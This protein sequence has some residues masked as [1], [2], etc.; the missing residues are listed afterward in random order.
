MG[1]QYGCLKAILSCTTDSD[2]GHEV[3]YNGQCKAVCRNNDDCSQNEKCIQSL[4][5]IPCVG[6]SQCGD[7]QACINGTCLLGCRTDNNCPSKQACINGKC[8]NPCENDGVCGP[9]AICSCE[10]HSVICKCPDG[11]EG[12]PTPEQACIRVPASCAATKDCPARHMCIANKCGLPCV[13][14]AHCAIG[15]RCSNNI[16]VKVCHA[17]SNCLPGDVC[18]KGVCQAGCSTDS[19]CRQ[20]EICIRNQCKCNNGFIAT[21]SGCVDINECESHPCHSSAACENEIGSYR[22]SCPKGTAGDPFVE[23]GCIAPSQCMVDVQCSDNLACRKGK[24]VDTCLETRCGPN[25]VC[26]MFNHLAACSCPPGHLGN[27]DD[28]ELGCFK[29]ECTIDSDCT[30]DRYCDVQTNKC[31]SK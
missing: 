2:C 28:S 22:C 1:V 9:N 16:C 23:P 8:Q 21:P 17:D 5:V 3:C 7:G 26:S 15:E 29:V 12:N 11:F 10:D 25:A 19:D 31:I 27:P 24:C 14:N 6:H 13:D 30:D 4:C 18:V 20:S